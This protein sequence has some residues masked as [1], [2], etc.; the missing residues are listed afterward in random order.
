MKSIDDL[1]QVLEKPQA[2]Q[3]APTIPIKP[4]GPMEIQLGVSP[5]GPASIWKLPSD[6][7]SDSS[8]PRRFVNVDDSMD[9]GSV[10]DEKSLSKMAPRN[11]MEISPFDNASDDPMMLEEIDDAELNESYHIG[12]PVAA[13]SRAPNTISSSPGSNP[14]H[15][16]S[17][18]PHHHIPVSFGPDLHSHS[19][20]SSPLSRSPSSNSAGPSEVAKPSSS[21]LQD[22]RT[23]QLIW[24]FE[25]I[26]RYC[27]STEFKRNVNLLGKT[28]NI[29][30]NQARSLWNYFGWGSSSSTTSNPAPS[31][32]AVLSASPN[33]AP[34]NTA[35]LGD[36]NSLIP[37]PDTDQTLTLLVVRTNWYG[38]DQYRFLRL[39]PFAFVRLRTDNY[40]PCEKTLYEHLIAAQVS[41]STIK[42]R[43]SHGETI[44]EIAYN[45]GD[46]VVAGMIAEAL[47]FLKGKGSV[48]V[49]YV[50]N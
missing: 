8:S 1:G 6:S 17:S 13:P 45:F 18:S 27:E 3:A 43:Y 48:A 23:K 25:G 5:P 41:G 4:A 26:K 47:Q 31:S 21:A 20:S 10:E 38:R 32:T 29:V 50:G 40:E 16:L 22:P 19:G 11:G 28:A 35:S 2:G 37:P 46:A 33:Q 42:F 14:P 9:V 44:A 30:E 49:S 36:P 39:E 34:P 12:S 7:M 15:S 24:L